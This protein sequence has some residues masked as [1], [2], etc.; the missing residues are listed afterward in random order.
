ME[1]K[2]FTIGDVFKYGINTIIDHFFT[3]GLGLL[4]AAGV[5]AIVFFT[6]L[7]IAALIIYANLSIIKL[8]I[9]GHLS[10]FTIFSELQTAMSFIIILIGFLI[11]L[12]V[13]YGLLG[14][15]IKLNLAIYDKGTGSISDI[16]SSFNRAPQLWAAGILYHLITIVGLMLLV[17]PRIFWADGIFYH[18]ITII[19]LVLLVI[20]GIY[21]AIRLALYPF[22]IIDQ[23]DEIINAFFKSYTATSGYFWEILIIALI[24]TLLVLIS[25]LLGFVI[26][27]TWPI[28]LT[29]IYRKLVAQPQR[30]FE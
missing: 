24:I 14:G 8:M 9:M 18:L 5:Y 12:F 10:I 27:L 22:F 21:L 26:M 20:P 16:F 15:F 3:L 6:W 1:A 11:V 25:S 2:R 19:G 17:I 4:A 7:S 28:M 23:H 30:S 13:Y 29:Y